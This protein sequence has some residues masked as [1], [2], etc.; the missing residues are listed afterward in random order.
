MNISFR[1]PKAKKSAVR[2]NNNHTTVS[3]NTGIQNVFGSTE[4]EPQDKEDTDPKQRTNQAILAEQEAIQRKAQNDSKMMMMLDEEYD[5]DGTYDQYKR[6]EEKDIPKDDGKT[7]RYMENI[8]MASEQREKEREI[9]R[10]RRI[11]REQEEEERKNPE[12][13]GKEKFVT[14]AYKRKLE[15]RQQ[16]LS[17]DSKRQKEE[18]QNDVTNKRSGAMIANFYGNLTRNSAMGGHSSELFVNETKESR[19][20]SSSFLGDFEAATGDNLASDEE[21]SPPEDEETRRMRERKERE[22]KV[23]EARKRYFAR[24]GIVST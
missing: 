5:F 4:D 18:E 23:E 16:W 10:E 19:P 1:K 17:E 3:S 6:P 7:S 13:Q 24:H 9:I 14:S 12:Y 21:P 8:L 2:K 15:E 11:L 20:S 22:I